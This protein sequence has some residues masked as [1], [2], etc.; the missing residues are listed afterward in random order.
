MY[1]VLVARKTPY[2]RVLKYNSI[3]VIR[4]TDARMASMF[5][6]LKSDKIQFFKRHEFYRILM[7]NKLT[8]TTVE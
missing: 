2:V 3:Y 8:L 6:A 5:I 1:N 4:P 7:A